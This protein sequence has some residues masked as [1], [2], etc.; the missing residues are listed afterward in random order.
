MTLLE[1]DALYA[2]ARGVE[3][4][5]QPVEFPP[6]RLFLASATALL[7]DLGDLN[8]HD[9]WRE[10]ARILRTCRR[11]ICTVP[12]PLSAVPLQLG[13]H[14]EWLHHWSLK[15]AP[16]LAPAQANLLHRAVE[17]LRALATEEVSPLAEAAA[18]FLSLDDPSDG[19]LTISNRSLVAVVEE[20]ISR[21]YP[22]MRV[23]TFASF[24]GTTKFGSAV[25][26]GPPSWMPASLFTAPRAEHLSVV[27]YQFFRDQPTVEP[28]F[29]SVFGDVVASSGVQHRVKSSR[30]YVVSSSRA[31]HSDAHEQQVQSVALLDSHEC[32]P[33]EEFFI[34]IR[35]TQAHAQ[36]DAPAGATDSAVE[37]RAAV[38]ASG[39]H[40]LLP[41]ESDVHVM[42]V[43]VEGRPGQRISHVL[44]SSVSPGDFLA[45]RPHSEH[46]DLLVRAN[47]LLGNDTE[48]L[49]SIQ[50][51][52]KQQLRARVDR[53]PR[54]ITGVS[55]DL[56]NM[57]ASTANIPYWTSSWCIR[58]RSKHDFTV[59]MSYLGRGEEAESV[60]T[61]LGLIDSAHRRIGHRSSSSIE[62]VLTPR[63]LELLGQEGWTE[64]TPQYRY[65]GRT[66]ITRIDQFLP[67]SH[68]VPAY[69]LCSLYGR[70]E[71]L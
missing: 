69:L 36:T 6:V 41:I 50:A 47:A 18:D 66:V 12:L 51:L 15:F 43:D 70:Q 13:E 58:T 44:A 54:G 37:A 40:V 14:G 31:P 71:A 42:T 30:P 29:A 1:A 22:G 4:W 34:Q 26:V 39:S 59:L 68:R 7:R 24:Q 9:L 28:L 32:S 61:D 21:Q 19:I 5:D 45:L 48:R 27:R 10:P 65:M 63:A 17:A 64:V 55:D 3:I 52:W 57:G 56:R 67:G 23:G 35:A 8:D 53:H 49:R 60:W 25:M 46:A 33:A 38:L 2:C 16:Q 11:A 20:A 62:E